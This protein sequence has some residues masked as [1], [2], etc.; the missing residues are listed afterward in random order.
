[1]FIV[2]SIAKI[3]RMYHVEKKSIKA[4]TRELKISKN[5][6]RKI[7][8]S[9]ATKFALAKYTKNKPVL[10]DYLSLLNELLE[11]NTKEPL[12]RRMTSRKLYEQ[13]QES[14]YQGSYESVNLVVKNFRRVNEAKGKQVFI[15]LSFEPGESFQ[16]DWGEEEVCLNGV[17]VRVKAARI[18][19]CY[20][21]HS[22]VVVY[23]N[24][25]LEM[26][27]SAHEEAF[28][29][30]G[31]CCKHGIYDNM[32]TAVKKI[33]IGK[34]RVFNEKFI[35]MASH[36]LFKPVA[37]TP[38]S[39][40]EKGR[41]EKQVGDTRR[42][43]FTPI[44]KGE[45]YDAINLQLKEKC[46]GWSKSKRH[47]ELQ[48]QTVLEVYEAEKGSLIAYRGAF[49]AYRL[50][51]TVVS[52]SS[53]V[54]YDT[55]MYSVECAYVGLAVH[56]QSYAWSII[57]MHEDN[58][59][60]QHNRCFDR[61]QRIYNP[62][63]YVPALERKPGALRNGAPFKDLMILLPEAFR[64]IRNKL[65]AHKDSDK[66]FVII[67]LLVSK[68]GIDRVSNACSKALSSGGCS[69]QLVQQY[70]QP[71]T[72][73]S[74]DDYIKLQNPPDADCSIYSKL[75]LKEGGTA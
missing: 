7:I 3:R 52:S 54:N 13:L 57:I 41:V 61:Y 38:A 68:Y 15:P 49:T 20:S 71:L 73:D 19:L 5:T 60:G 31:G 10:G 53:M 40:W 65:Q 1:M 66:Q 75:Y 48:D 32:K 70:L 8:R 9:D 35:Q 64:S 74:K 62:W 28:K 58:I 63:H 6:V 45:T 34:E 23:P 67:L 42:N 43:F 17:I 47:P 46:L 11:E 24:E 72:M 14:G 55:N 27:M 50:H 16:F 39:G 2:E 29:F 33:L 51:S 22:L 59:I 37:C 12:R 69:A 36:Y 25:Q 30:F 56:I 4:I 44:L 18:K 21:R 26:V